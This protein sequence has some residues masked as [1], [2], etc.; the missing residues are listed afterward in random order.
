[1][2]AFL[3]NHTHPWMQLPDGS[4]HTFPTSAL[5]VAEDFQGPGMQPNDGV[6][7]RSAHRY[8]HRHTGLAPSN[9]QTSLLAFG[10]RSR[11]L[12][13]CGHDTVWDARI[14]SMSTRPCLASYVLRLFIIQ[15]GI[16]RQVSASWGSIGLRSSDVGLIAD[17][18][19]P[20]FSSLRVPLMT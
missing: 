9:H 6:T 15:E 11:L 1:M 12:D 3:W 10:G 18:G 17:E 2:D 14:E 4:S 7:I 19:I 20:P 8:T 16:R 13:P 5:R